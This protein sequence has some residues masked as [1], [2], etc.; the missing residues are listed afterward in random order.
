M[1]VQSGRAALG[2]PLVFIQSLR[3]FRQAESEK[4]REANECRSDDLTKALE[5]R[6]EV[7]ERMR[8]QDGPKGAQDGPKLGPRSAPGPNVAQDGPQEG[9]KRAPDGPKRPN[10]G[11]R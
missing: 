10:M 1:C 3:A 8:A 4:H 9:P 5:N 6:L 11:P 7:Y 2:F